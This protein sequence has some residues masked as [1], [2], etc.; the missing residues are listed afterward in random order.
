MPAAGGP[1]GLPRRLHGT[2][3]TCESLYMGVPVLTMRGNNHRGRVGLSLLTALGLEKEFVA[4]SVE[5]YIARAIAWGRAP[6]YLADIRSTLRPKMEHS[7]L[8]DEIGFTRELEA[9]Y[10]DAWRTWCAGPQTFMLK[11]PPAL[12]PEDAIQ[13]VLVKKIA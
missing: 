12:R 8:R 11:A 2:T 4:E 10:R 3:T 13:G 5:D 1:V 9:A 7:A 6:K